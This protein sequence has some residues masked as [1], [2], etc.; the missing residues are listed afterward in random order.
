V[1]Y[2]YD[3][4][5][6]RGWMHKVYH[7]LVTV[8]KKMCGLNKQKVVAMAMSLER[9]QPNFTAIIY[10]HRATNSENSAKIGRV[11]FEEIGLESSKNWKHF[12]KLG[13]FKVIKNGII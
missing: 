4:R 11:Y 1:Y 9:S 10:A 2:T 7:T 5:A 8:T 13:S 12:R 6:R 3:G